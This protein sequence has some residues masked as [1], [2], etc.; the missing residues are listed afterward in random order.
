MSVVYDWASWAEATMC[1]LRIGG[2]RQTRSPGFEG[3]RPT[4]LWLRV[5]EGAPRSNPRA[6]GRGV[7]SDGTFGPH[8][9]SS[10]ATAEDESSAS[11]HAPHAEHSTETTAVP[12]S[13]KTPTPSSPGR[14]VLGSIWWRPSLVPGHRD[15]PP[16]VSGRFTSAG[17]SVNRRRLRCRCAITRQPLG[18]RGKELHQ[19]LLLLAVELL[20]I[21][22]LLGLAPDRQDR[23]GDE[24][25]EDNT[26]HGGWALLGTQSRL[27][28][29]GFAPVRVRSRTSWGCPAR[30]CRSV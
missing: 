26:V 21:L 5:Q 18:L 9:G 28:A 1:A 16:F 14:T 11:P 25:D 24:K 30:L 27:R 7:P 15:G 4:P 29:F 10:Q 23:G 12:S 22:L 6:P 8:Y 20:A 17:S 13:S 3:A 19:H 2:P